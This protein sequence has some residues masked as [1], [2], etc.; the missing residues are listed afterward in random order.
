M[1]DEATIR[2]PIRATARIS[3]VL[4]L[5]AFLG[6]DLVDEIDGMCQPAG[7]VQAEGF[8]VF[9]HGGIGSLGCGHSGGRLEQVPGGE[10]KMGRFPGLD[11]LLR[12]RRV[13]GQEEQNGA[14]IHKVPGAKSRVKHGCP[15]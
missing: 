14:E 8:V 4:F 13:G 15:D 7:V 3:F 12:G 11:G 1:M 5:G 9:E 6:E 2:V 10:R